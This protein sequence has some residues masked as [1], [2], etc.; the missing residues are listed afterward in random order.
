MPGNPL[1]RELLNAIRDYPHQYGAPAKL[2][3]LM[4]LRIESAGYENVEKAMMA[5][6][7]LERVIIQKEPDGA[8]LVRSDGSNRDG[9]AIGCRYCGLPRGDFA[10]WR[11]ATHCEHRPRGGP[12]RPRWPDYRGRDKIVRFGKLDVS[13]YLRTVDEARSLVIGRSV[14]APLA[15]NPDYA[16]PITQGALFS[17]VSAYRDTKDFI[18]VHVSDHRLDFEGGRRG[19]VVIVKIDRPDPPDVAFRYKRIGDRPVEEVPY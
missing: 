18:G 11:N 3:A 1:Q 14:W 16:V 2:F 7:R 8:W 13:H 9:T 19:C 12:C 6:Q 5:L 15:A 10:T 4:D 17:L